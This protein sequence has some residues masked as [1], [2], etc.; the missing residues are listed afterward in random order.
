MDSSSLP[1]LQANDF[2]LLAED[3]GLQMM[4]CLNAT[5]IWMCFNLIFLPLP[6][7]ERQVISIHKKTIQHI[8]SATTNV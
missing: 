3:M 8:S 2:H 6:Q 1:I 7:E 5:G 4:I